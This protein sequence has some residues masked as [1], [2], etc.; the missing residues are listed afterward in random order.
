MAKKS[1]SKL[2]KATED[3]STETEATEEEEADTE[4]TETMG[5][6][7]IEDPEGISEIGVTD[8]KD[9]STAARTDISPESVKNVIFL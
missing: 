1:K 3:G 9:A 7:T 4:G 2:P 5:S 8:L 6:E